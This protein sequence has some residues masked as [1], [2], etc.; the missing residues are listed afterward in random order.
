[1][2]LLAPGTPRRAFL[3]RR[4]RAA[5]RLHTTPT[6]TPLETH[7]TRPQQH[8]HGHSTLQTPHPLHS[9]ILTS[10]HPPRPTSR[11]HPRHRPRRL[12]QQSHLRR[13]LQRHHHPLPRPLNRHNRRRKNPP[14]PP[15]PPPKSVASAAS[16]STTANMPPKSTWPYPP[17]R[18]YS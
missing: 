8:H 13:H 18:Y 16:A 3:D 9:P 2:N 14:L 11:P 15:S 5:Y 1:M 6:Q 4:Q 7:N 12:P 17:S 10:S